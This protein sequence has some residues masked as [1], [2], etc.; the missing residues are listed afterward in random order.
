MSKHNKNSIGTFE[1]FKRR[2]LDELLEKNRIS[3]DGRNYIESAL[4]KPARNVAGTRYNQ[5]SDIPCPKMQW[6]S[7]AESATTENPLTIQL[8]FDTVV[9]GYCNQAP[10]LHLCYR[11]RNGKTVR[12]PYTP[13]CLVFHWRDG[14]ILEEWKPASARNTLEE[15]FPGKFSKR[16]DGTFGS[17]PVEEIICPWGFKFRLRFSDEVTP[18]SHANRVYLYSYLKPEASANYAPSTT[19]VYKLLGNRVCAKYSD[20]VEEYGSSDAINYLIATSRLHFDF[21]ATLLE[22]EPSETLIFRHAES[23]RAWQ[24]AKRPDGSKP[25]PHIANFSPNRDIAAGDRILFDGLK[26]TVNLVGA[27][28][29]HAVDIQRNF[30]TLNHDQLINSFRAG[31]LVLPQ[32]DAAEEALTPFWKASYKSLARAV[33]KVEILEKLDRGEAIIVEDRHSDPTYRRWRSLIRAGAL[34]GWSPVES[35]IDEVSARGFHG[36]H[37]DSEFSVNLNGWIKE[38]LEDPQNHSVISIYFKVQRLAEEAG[39]RM[40][41][42]SSF[43]ERVKQVRS[44]ETIKKSQGHKHQ[45]SQQPVYWMLDLDTPIHCARALEKVHFDSTLLDSEIRSSLSGEVLG[46]PWL[47]LAICANTRR[48]V[49]MYLSFKPPSQVSSMMLLCDIVRRFGRLPES[50]IHD[51][52][53]EF[54]GK[55]WKYAL[56]ALSVIRHTR[57]KSAAR[58]GAVLERMFGIVTREFLDNIAGN[59]KSRKNVR[60]LTPEADPTNHSGLWLIDLVEGLEEYFFDIYDNRKHPATLVAPRS[61]YETSFLKHGFRAHQ[62]RRLEDILPIL[63]PTASGKPRIVDP[64]RGLFV[65]YRYYGHPEL[66]KLALAGSSVEVKPLLFDPGSILAF[67]KGRWIICKSNLSERFSRCSEALRQCVYEEL[68]IEQRL[69][70]QSNHI[71]RRKLLILQERLNKKALANIEYWNDPQ[72]HEVLEVASVAEDRAQAEAITGL[73]KIEQRMQLAL[74]TMMEEK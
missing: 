23:L 26:L 49:G 47:S 58:F 67:S 52:G 15:S 35:L 60:K 48:V 18:I 31:V 36:S 71:S 43:Y 9:A 73:S 10:T 27:T 51:W 28:A 22:R 39:Q 59:T 45:Y 42:M 34:K 24:L 57:P 41:A 32:R 17:Q 40:V 11:G 1:P 16:P 68:Q 21:D 13:D 38:K 37:I 64:A 5:V 7:Q 20:L 19:E 72:A 8:V 44:L 54:K 55:D 29:I 50:I 65:N 12:A 61:G 74:A 6:N 33:R 25:K 46:R 2:M 70:T 14:F 62:L 63:M 3:K 66:T 53:S 30:L 69:V 56:T 4:A